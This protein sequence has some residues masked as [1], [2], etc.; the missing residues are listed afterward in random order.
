[1]RPSLIAA[2][3]LL[4]ACNQAAPVDPWSPSA[5]ALYAEL[6]RAGHPPANARAF[7]NAA[8]ADR[9]SRA[10]QKPSKATVDREKGIA[11]VQTWA[12]KNDPNLSYC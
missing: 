1:M 9:D 11:D 2:I 3:L 12:C 4:S 10:G 7:V 5:H 6:V 8:L